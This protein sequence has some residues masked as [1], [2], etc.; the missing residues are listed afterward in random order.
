MDYHDVKLHQ[1][2]AAGNSQ[3]H[4]E[5]KR[6]ILL[7]ENWTLQNFLPSRIYLFIETRQFPGRLQYLDVLNPRE[8]KLYECNQLNDGDTLFVFDCNKIQ[9]GCLISAI[10]TRRHLLLQPFTIRDFQKYI[11]IGTVVYGEFDGGRNYQYSFSDMSGVYIHNMMNYPVN[12]YYR[13]ALAAQVGAW[14]G[15]GYHSGSA[16]QVFFDNARE[17]LRLGDKLGFGYS[18]CES[19]GDGPLMFE[20]MITDNHAHNIY[21]GVVNSS[22]D[23]AHPDVT[24]YRVN[25]PA[26]T[27]VSYFKPVNGHAYFTVK[28]M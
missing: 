14:D 18:L 23:V 28:T 21:V 12:I 17:G 16:S 27:G 2:L 1:T 5:M 6:E 13:G 3:L 10:D 25:T 4:T 20:T 15:K 11:R 8:T 19:Q 22:D 24:A 26:H 7:H 9:D